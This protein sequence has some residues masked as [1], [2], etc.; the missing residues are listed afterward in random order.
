MYDPAAGQYGE[1]DEYFAGIGR[2]HADHIVNQ[3]ITMRRIPDFRPFDLQTEV[4]RFNPNPEVHYGGELDYPA[5]DYTKGLTNQLAHDAERLR[6][7]QHESETTSVAGYTE[8]RARDVAWYQTIVRDLPVDDVSAVATELDNLARALA[9]TSRT[10]LPHRLAVADREKQQEAQDR[11][12][13][14]EFSTAI[15]R[16]S[17]HLRLPSLHSSSNAEQAAEHNRLVARIAVLDTKNPHLLASLPADRAQI[18]HT[19]LPESATRQHGRPGL[20]PQTHA[21]NEVLLRSLTKATDE[22]LGTLLHPAAGVD[23]PAVGPLAIKVSELC[24]EHPELVASLPPLQAGLVR[25]VD[26]A[27]PRA[28]ENNSSPTAVKSAPAQ[29]ERTAQAPTR[30]RLSAAARPGTA[31]TRHGSAANTPG[32]GKGR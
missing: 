1:T 26:A 15:D 3:L 29:T 18:V 23:H 12:E 22:L 13:L 25:S 11:A 28:A 19:L 27:H 17:L 9:H 10:A 30:P 7:L 20:L 14:R 8:E 32:P 5:G 6:S 24:K 16:Y 21:P 4:D 2:A 31:A